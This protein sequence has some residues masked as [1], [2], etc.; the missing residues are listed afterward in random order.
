MGVQIHRYRHVSNAQQRQQTK[1][2][3]L[4]VVA[5]LGLS[6]GLYLALTLAPQV[7]PAGQVAALFRDSSYYIGLQLL[8][9]AI[10]FA[11]FRSG[12][13]DVDV[14]INRALVYGV[15]TALL[16][17]IYS[18]LVIG[19]QALFTR[20]TG[21]TS[22]LALIGSTLAI[23]ALFQPLRRGVAAFI[24]RRFYRRRYD[25]QQVLTAFAGVLRDR[26]YTDPDDLRQVLLNVVDETIR[27]AHVTLRLVETAGPPPAQAKPGG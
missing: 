26:P 2:V 18:G 22:D 7:N 6:L 27:P 16:A 10:G 24:D 21:Q 20:F 11:M 15:L 5:T 25:G 19:L 14:V 8:P 4:G 17:G 1:W 23:V 12:L 3:V 9:L 13:Y